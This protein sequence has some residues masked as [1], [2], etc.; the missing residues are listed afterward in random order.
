MQ[1]HKTI[2]RILQFKLSNKDLDVK[3]HSFIPS[4][5]L[6][7]K[8]YNID[9]DII[10]RCSAS[11]QVAEEQAKSEK[12]ALLEEDLSG[13]NFRKLVEQKPELKEELLDFRDYLLASSSQEET[14]KVNIEA[15]ENFLTVLQGH[16]KFD[17]R[18]KSHV[19]QGVGNLNFRWKEP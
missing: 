11:F 9:L 4:I 19:S 3:L 16:I 18:S 8:L 14:L 13:F 5:G 15:H 1:K 7:F 10:D 12:G 6:W 17:F 2:L